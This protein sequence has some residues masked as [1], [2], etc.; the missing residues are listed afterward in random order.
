MAADFFDVWAES[1]KAAMEAKSHGFDPA[2]EAH[3]VGL[4]VLVASEI[5]EVIDI[6]KKRYLDDRAGIG[7]ELADT[8]IRMGHL[9]ATLNI[10]LSDHLPFE[11]FNALGQSRAEMF[12]AFNNGMWPMIARLGRLAGMGIDISEGWQGRST[13]SMQRSFANLFSQVA[14]AAVALGIDLDKAIDDKMLFNHKRGYKFGV[15]AHA[16]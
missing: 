2:D 11:S 5:F 4:I 15:A 10:S 14:G 16:T 1:V 7:E 6:V 12:G 13:P 3:T 8:L 9:A